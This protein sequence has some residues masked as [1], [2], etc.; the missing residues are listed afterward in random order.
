[1]VKI[2]MHCAK[3]LNTKRVPKRCTGQAINQNVQGSCTC[4]RANTY[5]TQLPTDW[6]RQLYV[7]KKSLPFVPKFPR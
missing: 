3:L 6:L 2:D 7:Q 4:A 1:M 5:S